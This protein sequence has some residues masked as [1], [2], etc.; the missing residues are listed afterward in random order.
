MRSGAGGGEVGR[1]DALAFGAPEDE[2]AGGV[3]ALLENQF[4]AH[5]ATGEFGFHHDV[6]RIAEFG[7]KP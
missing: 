6:G 5:F 7:R 1:A 2:E 3:V 4:P